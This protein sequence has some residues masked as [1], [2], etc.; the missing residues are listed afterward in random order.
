MWQNAPSAIGRHWRSLWFLEYKLEAATPIYI[1][2]P[3]RS[4][5]TRSPP[6]QL[7]GVKF[8][9]LGLSKSTNIHDSESTPQTHLTFYVPTLKI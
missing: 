5:P 2:I 1:E 4:F 6:L 7:E 3:L 8:L 9:R